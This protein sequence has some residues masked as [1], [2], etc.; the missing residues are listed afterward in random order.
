MKN[1][2]LYRIAVSALFL[3]FGSLPAFAQ[4]QECAM[5]VQVPFEFQVN[6]TVLP[7]GKYVVRRDTQMPGILQVQSPD[8][9]IFVLVNTE[10]LNLSGQRAKA[11]LTFKEYEGKHFLSEVKFSRYGLGYSLTASKAERKLAQAAKA[12]MNPTSASMNN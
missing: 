10:P 1:Q 8:K 5:T 12:K 4:T 7:A 11:S 2:T 6:E 9:K 3:L